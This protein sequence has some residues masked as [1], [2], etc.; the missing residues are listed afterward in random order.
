MTEELKS[1]NREE[2]KLELV[3]SPQIEVVRSVQMA[4]NGSSSKIEPTGPTGLKI[5]AISDL[6]MSITPS[7]SNS[8]FNFSD[9]EIVAYLTWALRNYDQIILN[10]DVFD[11]WAV[12]RSQWGKEIKSLAGSGNLQEFV[13]WTIG[14]GGAERFTVIEHTYPL[15]T[16]LIKTGGKDVVAR[17]GEI[18]YVN[19]NHDFCCRTQSLIPNA[20]ESHTIKPEGSPYS[21][22]FAHGH[23]ADVWCNGKSKAKLCFSMFGY[24]M[25]NVAEEILE[26]PDLDT[27]ALKLAETLGISHDGPNCKIYKNHAHLMAKRNKSDCVI[28]GHTHVMDLAK[29]SVQN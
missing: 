12:D 24:C 3:I 19:G 14:A 17:R 27:N 6:H 26:Y 25:G 10:G 23:Q 7:A 16:A 8:M 1:D 15:T 2:V 13:D 22:Y 28:Y 11:C 5:L 20:K 4:E 18:I 21:I 29:K 9:A